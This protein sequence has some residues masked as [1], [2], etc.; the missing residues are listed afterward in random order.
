MDVISINDTLCE[1]FR[2]AINAAYP[3]VPDPPVIVTTS[4]NPKFG[5]YQCNSAMPLAQQ[6]SSSGKPQSAF[7]FS[8]NISYFDEYV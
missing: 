3:D 4:N 1:I 7:T 5:D 8:S 6:L 2:K